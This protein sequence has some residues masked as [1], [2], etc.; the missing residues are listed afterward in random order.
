M[1]KDRKCYALALFTASWSGQQG[2][3]EA[4]G[5]AGGLSI[6]GAHGT[7]LLIGLCSLLICV[8]KW[9]LLDAAANAMTFEKETQNRKDHF[10]F[11]C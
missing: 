6:K 5:G 8:S 3:A 9:M 1:G 11:K 4:F 2:R 10:K 7:W